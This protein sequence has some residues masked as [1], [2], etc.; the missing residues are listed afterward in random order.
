MSNHI[1]YAAYGSNMMEERFLCYIRGG[2]PAGSTTTY[3][4]C[5]D[6]SL[7]VKS[8]DCYIN[9]E[10]YFARKSTTWNNGGVAFIKNNFAPSA[11]TFAKIYLIT[12]EQFNQVV[13]Q[14]IKTPGIAI[15]FTQTKRNGSSIIKQNSW[16]GRIIYLGDQGGFPMFTFTAENDHVDINRPNDNYLKTIIKGIQE[17]HDVDDITIMDYLLSTEGID[18]NIDP[19]QLHE[20]ITTIE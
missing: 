20:I 18:G 8:E 19:Q 12:E 6:Q 2:T 11:S 1:W 16:Y 17:S 14:E 15:N 5:A 9:S 7:P 4:G 3:L 13:A 10:L